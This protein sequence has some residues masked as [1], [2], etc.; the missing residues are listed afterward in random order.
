[1][2]KINKNKQSTK[3]FSGVERV[4]RKTKILSL[5]DDQ[6]V[7]GPVLMTS[8]GKI[9]ANNNRNFPCPER[10]KTHSDDIK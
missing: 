5:C 10:R 6:L 2:Y 7:N 3:A 8:I 4:F 1:M 9:S